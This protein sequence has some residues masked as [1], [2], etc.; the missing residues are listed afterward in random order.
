MNRLPYS[1][2]LQHWQFIRGKFGA[3]SIF[4]LISTNISN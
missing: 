1:R 3:F 2:L 4:F